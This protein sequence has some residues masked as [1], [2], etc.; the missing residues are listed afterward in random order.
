MPVAA[1]REQVRHHVVHGREEPLRENDR[2]RDDG[3]RIE[4]QHH[5]HRPVTAEQPR[6]RPPV[7]EQLPV[8]QRERD[9]RERDESHLPAE[10]VG[11]P[12]SQ[13]HEDRDVVDQHR[14]GVGDRERQVPPRGPAIPESQCDHE[15]DRDERVDEAVR[16]C[17]REGGRRK[18]RDEQHSK[19][20]RVGGWRGD[21]VTLSCGTATFFSHCK[22][23]HRHQCEREEKRAVHLA[24]HVERVDDEPTRARQNKSCHGG[25]HDSRDAAYSRRGELIGR[26][27]DEQQHVRGHRVERVHPVRAERTRG[28]D[29]RGDERPVAPSATGSGRPWSAR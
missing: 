8:D 23:H 9:C 28:R 10:L 4:Q 18:R 14:H 6:R 5:E 13:A 7:R 22:Q 1:G 29:D 19:R 12:E 26:E 17:Q 15:Q 27:S 2:R 16:P 3:E 25:D 21:V 24:V 11:V 20:T